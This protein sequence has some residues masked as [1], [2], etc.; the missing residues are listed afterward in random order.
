M[1]I[2]AA[3]AAGMRVVALTTSFEAAHFEQLAAPPTSVCCD[4]EEYL[5]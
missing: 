1:G 2:E 5:R 4:F 3:Q